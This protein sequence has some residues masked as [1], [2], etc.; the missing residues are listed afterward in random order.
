V[1][2]FIFKN[3]S[4]GMD[5]LALPEFVSIALNVVANY[6]IFESNSSPKY[7]ISS[8]FSVA[9]GFLTFGSFEFFLDLDLV[10]L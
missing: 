6:L 3:T 10:F 5:T 7:L 9:V 8:Y 2:S 1:A 4:S